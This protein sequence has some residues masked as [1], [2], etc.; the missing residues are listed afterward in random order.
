MLNAQLLSDPFLGKRQDPN[1]KRFT[2]TPLAFPEQCQFTIIA[3]WSSGM[4]ES[5][6]RK[7]TLPESRRSQ[8]HT[9]KLLNVAYETGSNRC[10]N[11]KSNR[12]EV[13]IFIACPIGCFTSADDEIVVGLVGQSWDK[14]DLIEVCIG[15][16][17]N[18]V[19]DQSGIGDTNRLHGCTD[20]LHGFCFEL[21]DEYAVICSEANGS[22]EDSQGNGTRCGYPDKLVWTGLT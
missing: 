9:H 5:A 20:S 1:Q 18:C 12:D 14:L 17:R 15:S 3:T 6:W 22:S 4:V 2:K 13:D 19:G 21:L 10:D 16:Q 11:T 7:K 8:T